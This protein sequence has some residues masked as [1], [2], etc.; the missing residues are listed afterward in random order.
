MCGVP[1]GKPTITRCDWGYHYWGSKL[2][3][4]SGDVRAGSIPI[5]FPACMRALA[6]DTLLRKQPSLSFRRH[7]INVET[8]E[9]RPSRLEKLGPRPP[10]KW[11][12]LIDV[13]KD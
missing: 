4:R 12:L 5:R 6:P 9:L 13:G 10:E 7:G 2:F 3:P 11:F 8:H 1:A